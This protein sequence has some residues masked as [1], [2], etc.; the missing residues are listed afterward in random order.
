MYVDD[1]ENQRAK[2]LTQEEDLDYSRTTGSCF[3]ILTLA[4]L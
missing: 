3:H 4:L 1:V 2:R